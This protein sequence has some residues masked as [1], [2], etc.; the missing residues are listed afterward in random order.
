MAAQFVTPDAVH[1]MAR[2]A[3]GRICLALT[4][5]RYDDLRLPQM[6]SPRLTGSRAA[7]SVSIRARHGVT[8]GASASDRARTVQVAVDPTAT[9]SDLSRPGHVFPLRAQAGGVLERGER[10]EAG[11]DLARLAGLNPAA[12]VCELMRQDRSAGR[13]PDVAMFSRQ[14]R[15]QMI[16]I[17]D[18]IQY[19][20]R[21]ERAVSEV[22]AIQ[23]PTRY[24]SFV[25]H[26]FEDIWE[27]TVHL[28][29]VHAEA[30]SDRP[31]VVR[32]HS[33]CVL[34]ETFAAQ[35]CDCREGFELAIRRIGQEPH[36]I[37][38][39]VTN[40][41]RGR[42]PVARHASCANRP[43]QNH[44]SSER[45]HKADESAHE[46]GAQIL[47]ELG[48]TSVRALVDNP[49]TTPVLEAFGLAVVEE[50]PLRECTGRHVA[51]PLES[52]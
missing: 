39:Y 50:I 21:S 12:V 18:V 27:G 2:E 8:T 31:P 46:I 44:H 15:L 20:R 38:L 6:P 34:G 43:S 14:H 40:D 30:P 28:A 47:R 49:Q 22:T 7:S 52:K 32:V 37:L 13:V 24:G 42:S 45:S 51:V 19:R 4:P 35:R 3:R 33:Q 9:A 1:F 5:G 41:A 25:L 26:A 36:G 16:T 23:L 17:Q 11:V 29:L 10:A 48:L